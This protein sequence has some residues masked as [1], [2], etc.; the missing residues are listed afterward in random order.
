MFHRQ[1]DH[2]D[3]IRDVEPSAQGCEDCLKTGDAW[4]HLKVPDLWSRRLLRSE[5]QPPRHSPLP[6]NR[7]SHNEVL[8]AGRRLAVVL[9]RRGAGLS[10]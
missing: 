4:V 10:Q 3:Q 7:A 9:R 1:C 8:R 6:R 5:S 2:T